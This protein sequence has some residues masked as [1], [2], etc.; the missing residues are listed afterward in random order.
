MDGAAKS[1]TWTRGR[2]NERLAQML[3]APL[4]EKKIKEI[5]DNQR[6]P[7]KKHEQAGV[8]FEVHGSQ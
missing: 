4:K 8:M 5:K 1:T 7:K 6:R 3:G 2:K